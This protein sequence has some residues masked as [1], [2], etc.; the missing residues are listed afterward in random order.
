MVEWERQDT[1]LDIANSH[2]RTCLSISDIFP[3]ALPQIIHPVH[4]P[5]ISFLSLIK[6]LLISSFDVG[7][8]FTKWPPASAQAHRERER[9]K[10]LRVLLPAQRVPLS[11]RCC[12]RSL[13]GSVLVPRRA[14]VYRPVMRLVRT[15][16]AP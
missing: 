14:C 5:P 13:E 10:S 16:S 9:K 6:C 7:M 15:N 2:Y 4:K 12:R 8:D 1:T 11:V 3:C